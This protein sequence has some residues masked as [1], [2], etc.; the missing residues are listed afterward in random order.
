MTISDPSFGQLVLEMSESESFGLSTAPLPTL[1]GLGLS[2]LICLCLAKTF[3]ELVPMVI[4]NLFRE[5][6]SSE[7]ETN[8][9]V[10][11][12][13]N[14]LCFALVVP[15]VQVIYHFRIYD[16]AFVSAFGEYWRLPMIFAVAVVFILI[17][18]I[19]RS[20]CQPKYRHDEYMH[21]LFQGYSFFIAM[22]ALILPTAAI[23]ALSGASNDLASIIILSETGLIYLLLLIRKMQ[24]LSRFCSPFQLFLYLCALELLPTGLLIASVF[25]S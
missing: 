12:N 11:E 17:R 3:F 21:T 16:P 15:V 1:V 23:L 8:I 5:R 6:R 18:T 24:I 2:L 13:R 20:S 25:V 4:D 22:A 10:S 9:R 14:I 19:L 7:L